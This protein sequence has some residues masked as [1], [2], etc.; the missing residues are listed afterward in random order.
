MIAGRR[1]ACRARRIG[2]RE[3]GFVR[4]DFGF[5]DKSRAVFDNNAAGTEIADELCGG[6]EFDAFGG[7]DVTLHGAVDDD[8]FGFHLALDVGAFADGEG[9][10]GLDLALDFSVE[11]EV[12]LELEGAFDFNVAGKVVAV[13]AAGR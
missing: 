7:V 6:F 13:A 11:H 12:V 2:A 3:T 5:T 10:V 1:A 4:A 9:G 8:G